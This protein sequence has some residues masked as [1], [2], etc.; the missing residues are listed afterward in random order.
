MPWLKC[1]WNRGILAL[2]LALAALGSAEAQSERRDG[3]PVVRPSPRSA[4][5]RKPSAQD[6]AARREATLLYQA[7]RL[8]RYDLAITQLRRLQRE[9]SDRDVQLALL[10]LF[11]EP[12]E[13]ERV[14]AELA[15]AKI[16]PEVKKALLDWLPSKPAPAAPD[17][18]AGPV[19]PL[20]PLPGEVVPATPKTPAARPAPR[21]Y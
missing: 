19:E 21:L 11:P 5:P 8:R 18:G 4:T 13:V 3:P 16:A 14:R 7:L 12:A 20:P 10:D 1:P 9:G 2:T 15:A 17:E 6:S